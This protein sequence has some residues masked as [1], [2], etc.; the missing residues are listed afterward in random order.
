[1][2]SK[3][4]PT[5]FIIVLGFVWVV[6]NFLYGADI[7]VELRDNLLSGTEPNEFPALLLVAAVECCPL[8][9]GIRIAIKGYKKMQLLYLAIILGA[10]IV[11]T[12]TVRSVWEYEDLLLLSQIRRVNSFL[13]A[14]KDTD[15]Y[16]NIRVAKGVRWKTGVRKVRKRYVFI[17]GTVKTKEDLEQFREF[18]RKIGLGFRDEIKVES[19]PKKGMAKIKKLPNLKSR[20]V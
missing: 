16:E 12:H 1:M 7:I 9:Y 2:I 17:W 13:E 18:T 4:G 15:K 19:T 11:F 10:M 14:N 8:Y 20:F 3:W 6:D 5:I